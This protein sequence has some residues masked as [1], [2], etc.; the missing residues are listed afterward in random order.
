MLHKKSTTE[1][2]ILHMQLINDVWICQ[3][4]LN[5]CELDDIELANAWVAE[6]RENRCWKAEKRVVDD[7]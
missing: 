4:V 5:T 3:E 2:I 7:S 6:D 1:W